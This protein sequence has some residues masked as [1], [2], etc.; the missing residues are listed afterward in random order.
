MSREEWK[1]G[2][3]TNK[4]LGRD[5]RTPHPGRIDLRARRRDALPQPGADDQAEARRAARRDRAADRRRA[6]NGC[7]SCPTRATRALRDLT[8]AAVTGTLDDPDRPPAQARDGPRVPRRVHRA[9][10]S[11]CGAPPS[12]CAACCG[13]CS[14]RDRSLITAPDSARSSAHFAGIATQPMQ[15]R[16]PAAAPQHACRPRRSALQAASGV[17]ST[18]AS[19]L[20]TTCVCCGQAKSQANTVV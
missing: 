7:A 8:P 20:N 13:S 1:G 16:A 18:C 2:A 14:A 17:R 6:T 5:G 9:A 15:R 10:T 12:R 11:C 19:K 4:I 3:E